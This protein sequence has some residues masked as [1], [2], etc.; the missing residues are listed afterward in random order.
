MVTTIADDPPFLNWV[1]LD[2]KTHEVKYGIR[3]E[4]NPHVVGP[5]DVS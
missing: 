4:S 2:K 3:A 5:W 1:Y